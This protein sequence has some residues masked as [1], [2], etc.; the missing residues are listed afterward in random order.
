MPVHPRGGD[1]A[2]RPAAQRAA[3]A[4]PTI[5]PCVSL[6]PSS[7]P[8]AVGSSGVRR[9]TRRRSRWR[10]PDRPSATRPGG[11]TSMRPAGRSSSTSVMGARRSRRSW[12]ARPAVSPTR[13]AA[14]SRPSR[15]RPTPPRSPRCCRWT[16]RRS[17]RSRA[18]PR[19]SRRPSSSSAPITW[20]AASP[21][22]MSSS[23]GTAATTATRSGPW[24]CR[25]VPRCAGRTSPGWAGSGTSRRPTRTA[26][27]RPR[28]TPWAMGP[29]SPPSS[30]PP[31]PRRVRVAW[32]PSS[33]SPSSG[34]RSPRRCHRTTTGRPSRRSARATACCWSPTRS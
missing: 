20:P 7:R 5:G 25:A 12:P 31:S 11:S 4:W 21:T 3:D 18:V 8:R 26:P 14:R 24:T 15:S 6:G 30:R 33:R 23:P 1:R 10:R 28:P 22:V 29:P 16:I 9:S 32:R 2:R 27:A 34:R 13:T 19:R 17:T